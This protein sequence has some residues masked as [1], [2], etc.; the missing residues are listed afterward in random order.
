MNNKFFLKVVNYVA[1]ILM[2][3][4]IVNCADSVTFNEAATIEPVGFWH[5]VWHGITLIISFWGQL[6]T[7]NIAIYAIYNNGG[8]YDLGFIIGITGSGG[9]IIGAKYV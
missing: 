8:W 5:G 2:L 9:F 4:L 3:L 1:F 6:F 7:D